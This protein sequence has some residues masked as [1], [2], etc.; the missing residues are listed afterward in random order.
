[1]EEL[2]KRREELLNQIRRIAETCEGIDNEANA[3][4]VEELNGRQSALLAKKSELKSNL[5]AVDSELATVGKTISDLSAAGLDRILDAIKNQR[6]F[7]FKNKPKVLMDRDTAILWA[8]LNY[9]P[10]LKNN[11]QNYYSN[12]NSYSEVRD[13]IAKT[14]S[15]SFGGC[16]DWKI[17]TPFEFWKMIED[18]SFPFQEGEYWCI[19]NRAQW[20]VNNNGSFICKATHESASNGA[21]NNFKNWAVTVLPC[22]RAY[23]PTDYEQNISPS[24]NFYTEKEKLQFTLNIFVQNELIPMFNDAEITQL[25]R[26]IFVDKPALLK[27]LAEVDAQIAESEQ[28][29]IRLTANFNYRPILAKYDVA[30]VNKSAIKYFD[31]VLS[32]TD[33]LLNVLQEYEASQSETIAE[34]LKITLNLGAKYTDNPNL[35]AEENSLLSE[36]QKILARRLE[37]GIDEPKQKL[38][39]VKMQAENFFAHLDKINGDN[40]SIRQLAELQAEPRADFELLVENMARIIREVQQRVDFF[41]MHKE[42]VSNVVK[43]HIGWSNDYKTFKTSLREELTADC[44]NDSIDDEIFAAWYEDWQKKRLAIEQTFLP[45]VEFGLKGALSEAVSKVL[46][47]LGEYRGRIDNFY[48]H[49]RKNVYQKFAFVPGGDLQEKF[50]TESALYKLAEKFQRDLQGIIFACDKTEERIFLLRWSEPILNLPI[51]EISNF[52]RDKELDSIAEEVL[53][54]FTELRRKNFAEYLA[55]SKAYS[56]AA[57]NRENEFN[58]LIF[59]MRKDLRKN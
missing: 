23:V 50:E 6:W 15:E 58:A 43:A 24:N 56:E 49:D 8:D 36:R 53:T 3:K 22:S 38:L 25:Y 14:N 30:A 33:E 29:Q 18:K 40:S 42:F 12:S 51:E 59:R 39:F 7:F 54:Q 27:Q 34:F 10:Y 44:R 47:F 17:P 31:A 9:F 16:N 41:A 1:M 26:K 20:I 4:R 21:M 46:W 5:A 57:Q 52:I 2:L 35:T 55:D 37:I 45:L 28:S 48:L 32:V 11:N 19:K 13:L